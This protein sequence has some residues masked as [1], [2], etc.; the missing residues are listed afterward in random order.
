MPTSPGQDFL[1]LDNKDCEL[2]FS[3]QDPLELSK[4]ERLFSMEDIVNFKDCQGILEFRKKLKLKI[5]SS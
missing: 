3:T 1:L 2:I 4:A 5:S